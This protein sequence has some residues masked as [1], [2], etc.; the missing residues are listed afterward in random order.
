MSLS[1]LLVPNN[2]H[3]FGLLTGVEAGT[4]ITVTTT[5]DE[6]TVSITPTSVTAGTYT[7]PAS[8]Q[9][10]AEG[11]ILAINNGAGTPAPNT[12]AYLIVGTI[13]GSLPDARR[14]IAGQGLTAVD[15]GAGNTFTILTATLPYFEYERTTSL[16]VPEQTS[17][18]ISTWDTLISSNGIGSQFNASTGIFTAN[19]SLVGSWIFGVKGA[20]ATAASGGTGL[21][22]FYNTGSTNLSFDTI[23][24]DSSTIAGY[25]LTTATQRLSN[26]DTIQFNA[27]NEG[28]GAGAKTLQATNPVTLRC[29]AFMISL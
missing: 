14:I 18:V 28:L 19:T 23:N 12:G 7:N 27:V 29:W 8:V 25:R 5:N 21:S 4:G 16:S 20:F 3:L 10:N 24:A 9:V 26:G 11:Q 2:Y 17:V 22:I 6:A 1:N 13:P 15:S